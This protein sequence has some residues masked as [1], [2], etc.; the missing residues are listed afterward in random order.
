MKE[1]SFCGRQIKKSYSGMCQVCYHYFRTQGYT[2]FNNVEYGK[3]S[4][5]EDKSSPQ[6]GMP[7]CHICHRAYNKLQQHIYYSHGMYKPEYCKQFGL[8]N[9]IRMTS[10]PYYTKMRDYAYYYDM[11]EQVKQVGA[12][13]RFKKGAVPNYKRSYMTMERLRKQGSETIHKNRLK[14]LTVN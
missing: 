9:K 7:I 11:D 5:V 13:T 6:Y 12:N 2:V 3:L 4:Y 1:C 14:K 8:D 10:E